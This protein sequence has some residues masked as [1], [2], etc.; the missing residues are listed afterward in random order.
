MRGAVE[1][2]AAPDRLVGLPPIVSA[3]TV[4]LILGSFPGAQSLAARQ[5]YAHRQ[6][7]FWKILQTIWADGA[8]LA[9]AGSYERKSE[10]LLSKGLGLWDVYASCDRVGSLDSAIKNAAL[11]DFARLARHCPRLAAVAHN[12][13]ASFRHAREVEAAL[14]PVGET[15][16]PIAFYRLPS[17]S[18]ANASQPFAAKLA[19]WR[20][21]FVAHGLVDAEPGG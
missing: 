18:P 10:W 9:G 14:R 19:A 12:G 1:P 13:A 3:S 7:G 11:N 8:D 2:V 17:T 16:R 4:V 20:A 5:Y 21:V 6:N 15:A